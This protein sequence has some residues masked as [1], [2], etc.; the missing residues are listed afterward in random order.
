MDDNHTVTSAN[1]RDSALRRFMRSD[2]AR[3]LALVCLWIAVVLATTY[4][5]PI[6]RTEAAQATVSRRYSTLRLP[7]GSTQLGDLQSDGDACD[8]AACGCPRAWIGGLYGSHQPAAA[9]IDYYRT[10]DAEGDPWSAHIENQG[11]TRLRLI[12]EDEFV[13]TIEVVTEDVPASEDLLAGMPVEEVHAGLQQY[14]T[15][16]EVR[17][18]YEPEPCICCEGG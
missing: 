13:L 3:V 15:V 11:G 7:P 9:I 4:I 6:V 1:Q 5:V 14:A 16:L 17:L 8:R 10:W 12:D 18:E 2:W